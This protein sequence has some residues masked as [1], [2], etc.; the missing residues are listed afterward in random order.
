MGFIMRALT[1]TF[2]LL[3]SSAAVSSSVATEH[4]IAGLARTQESAAVSTKGRFTLVRLADGTFEGAHGTFKT[5]KA[6]DGELVWVILVHRQ[7]AED[8]RKF[9]K[10]IRDKSSV[11]VVKEEPILDTSGEITADTA[12]LT[13]PSKDGKRTLTA[14][15]IRIGDEFR[16]AQSYLS[17]DA[18]AMGELLKQP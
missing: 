16:D 9:Y 18:L 6:D 8:A 7:S 4:G 12:V 3:V 15:I 10:S 5:Y 2:G 13:M 11:V 14:V 17:S 1:L